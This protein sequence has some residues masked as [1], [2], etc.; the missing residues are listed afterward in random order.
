MSVPELADGS[1][2]AQFERMYRQTY[3]RM[4]TLA[5]VTLHDRAAAEDAVQD[6]YAQ[7]WRRWETVEQPSA[8]IR[9]AVVSTCISM[10]RST[11]RRGVRDRIIIARRPDLTLVSEQEPIFEVADLISALTE[12]QRLA[13]ALR[14]L[15]DLSELEIAEVLQC[16]PG[17]VKSTLNRA[18]KKL[19]VVLDEGERS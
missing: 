3:P 11:K 8:W 16:R 5:A 15:E 12:R 9:K 17:T 13:V 4:L 10:L 19:R 1:P 18:L 7:L 2:A 6:A 14:Y